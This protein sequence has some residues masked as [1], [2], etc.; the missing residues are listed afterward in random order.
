MDGNMTYELIYRYTSRHRTLNSKRNSNKII[1]VF[2]ENS[3]EF[4]GS[5]SCTN[6]ILTKFS[7]VHSQQQ[8]NLFYTI[9]HKISKESL[10]YTK[11]LS[12]GKVYYTN[13]LEEFKKI[14][15][16]KNLLDNTIYSVKSISYK[17]KFS[18]GKLDYILSITSYKPTTA[19]DGLA[20][21]I[22]EEM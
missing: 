5:S 8:V 9:P 16:I 3:F 18:N 13:N 20:R 10:S 1:G 4:G 2:L 6:K 11:L 7:C 22:L 14:P 15:E 19:C 17:P 21:D 12:D